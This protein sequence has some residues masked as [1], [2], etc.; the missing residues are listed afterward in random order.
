MAAQ[1]GLDRSR[2]GFARQMLEL[3]EDLLDL[4]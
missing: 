2:G 3:G 4:V 1:D